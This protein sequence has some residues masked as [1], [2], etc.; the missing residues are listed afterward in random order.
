MMSEHKHSILI[1]K[2]EKGKYLQYF[3]ER[4]N[5]Y[6]FPNC[7]LVNDDHKQIIINTLKDK[8][9]LNLN[10]VKIEYIMDKIHTKFS[11]SAKIEKVYHHFFYLIDCGSMPDYMKEK[12]FVNNDIKFTW[13]N[14]DEME[15]D[16]RIMET[17]S[18]VVGFV[19][20][21]IF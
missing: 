3:E 11:E 5:S 4:W 7:K 2:N 13:F 18:D 17:N 1:L 16:K 15:K 9:K 6:L 19:K 14:I 21:I 12:S 8:F 20:E 10:G